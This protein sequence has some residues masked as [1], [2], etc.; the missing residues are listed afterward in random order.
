[1]KAMKKKS[2]TLANKASTVAEAEVREGLHVARIELKSSS[3]RKRPYRVR[4]ASGAVIPA[5]IGEG[6]ERAFLDDCLAARRSVIL[7]VE[8][9]DAVIAGAL[10]TARAVDNDGEGTVR[11]AGKKLDLSAAE[12]I[13][14]R[15]GKSS[16]KL[17]DKGVI[18]MKGTN[19]TLDI[20]AVV[21]VLSELVE[22]P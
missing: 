17:D 14:L 8:N 2:N 11:I 19:L 10:Q 6:V 15:A 20:A 13:V 1:M 21:R 3:D 18:R 9:G 7:T 16:L 5:R 12:G 4:L 22:L